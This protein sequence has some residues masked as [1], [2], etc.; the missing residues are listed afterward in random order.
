MLPSSPNEMQSK[1]QIPLPRQLLSFWA[2][3]ANPWL[4]AAPLPPP[5]PPR[6]NTVDVAAIDMISTNANAKIRLG[7]LI[8]FIASFWF[9]YTLLRMKIDEQIV[10]KI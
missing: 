6:A 2:C 1:R 8:E 3:P 4:R 10:N 7:F 5:K 9:D